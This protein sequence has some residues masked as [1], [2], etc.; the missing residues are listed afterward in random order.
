MQEQVNENN[1]WMGTCTWYIMLKL[2]LV[3]LSWKQ[4]SNKYIIYCFAPRGRTGTNQWKLQASCGFLYR[5][6]ASKMSLPGWPSI[7]WLKNSVK[8]VS[9]Q[10]HNK[11]TSTIL[12]GLVKQWPACFW[13]C[14]SCM[15]TCQKCCRRNATN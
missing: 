13:R 14:S 7:L 8:S 5:N 10:R 12:S 11:S 9:L 2:A 4:R 6:L 1:E 3:R 15:T